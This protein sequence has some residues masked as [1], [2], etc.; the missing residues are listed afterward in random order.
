MKLRYFV[1]P[2]TRW[3]CRRYCLLALNGRTVVAVQ[4]SRPDGEEVPMPRAVAW[5]RPAERA[6]IGPAPKR[7]H[8]AGGADFVQR[9]ALRGCPMCGLVKLREE[10]MSSSGV[11]HPRKLCRTCYDGAKA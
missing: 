6:L 9:R 2:A 5:A 8:A 7:L 1:Q 11:G 4:A 3:C 10:F